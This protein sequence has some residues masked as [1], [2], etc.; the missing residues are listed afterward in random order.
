MISQNTVTKASVLARVK[1]SEFVVIGK[2]TIAVLTMVNGFKFT[3]E[4][5]CIDEVNFDK[6]LSEE[7]SLGD[8][9]KKAIEFEAY[10]MQEK[11]YIDS[12]VVKT[13]ASPLTA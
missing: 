1:S 9:L 5:A 3:G 11:M 12:M 7:Y 8:A 2:L 6:Q 13:T 4:S 10:L